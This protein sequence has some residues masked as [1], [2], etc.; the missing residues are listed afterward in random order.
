MYSYRLTV[1]GFPGNPAGPNNLGL[2]D[3]RLAVEWVRDNIENFGGDPARI[4]LF[5][6]SAGAVSVDLYSY[7]WTSDPIA[8]GFIPE[9]GTAFSWGLPNTKEQGAAAWF[10]VTATLGCGDASSNATEVL[11][12][13]RTK[14]YTSILNAVPTLTGVSSILGSYGPTI[15]DT[16]VYS[17][18]STR[19]PAKIP[20]LI[21]NN[22]YEGGL[23]RTELA[24]Q[25]ITFPDPFW[26]LFNL[27]EFTC[28]TGIRANVSLAAGIPTWRYRYFGVFP[29]LAVSSE[30][31]TWHAAELPILFDTMPANPGPTTAEISIA[32]YMRGAWAAFAKDPA[33]GLSTY[34]DGWPVYDPSKDTLIR[35]AYNNV[36]G[37]NVASP[38]VYDE[39]C[40]DVN[41]HSTNTSAY[42]NFHGFNTT[43]SPTPSSTGASSTSSASGT[44]T[45]SSTGTG[46]SAK[47][48]SGSRKVGMSVWF[49]VAAGV[50]L[51]AWL[52]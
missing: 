27:Q 19:T 48:T 43:A 4:T 22:N 7:A 34:G 50:G 14:N 12:C 41:V 26:D 45:G 5:G 18:Y 29:D 25:N 6:Q 38:W 32:N 40:A 42:L 52:L 31:G 21:G 49:T 17:N 46:S 9:S 16:V 3:Q 11:A 33:K 44:A 35:L 2:L 23:F 20:V 51:A 30:A 24:L 15:D 39:F 28:P 47:P 8:A 10:N 1:L 13:M 36:T 37:T